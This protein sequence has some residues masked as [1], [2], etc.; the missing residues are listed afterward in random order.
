MHLTD[1]GWNPYFEQHYYD[2][3]GVPARVSE[4]NRGCYRV[5]CEQ[6]EFLAYVPGRIRFQAIDRSDFPAV[7]D[8]I[9][10]E[11]W[12]SG[13]RATIT[14]ILPRRT[15]LSRKAAG[16]VAEEQ[17]LAANLDT[18]FIVTSFNQDF[19]LRRIERY[20][21]TVSQSG[22][23]PVLILNKVDV[24]DDPDQF[25]KSTGSL[26]IP[27]LALSAHTG[28]GMQQIR[29]HLKPGHTAAMIGSSGVGKSTILN[30]LT[31]E[32][33]QRIQ[34]IRLSDD[35]GK[36]TTTSRQ[37]FVIRDGGIL[38]DTP[39]IREL[40]LWDCD[41]GLEQAFEELHEYATQCR[42]RDCHHDGEPGCAVA[43][44]VEDGALD[45][46]RLENYKKL[47]AESRFMQS[48]I[49]VRVRQEQKARAKR[50]CKAQK[51]HYQD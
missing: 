9:V 45:S 3:A 47:L 39:G 28:E 13:E 12:P 37:L 2:H 31:G 38:I 21:A 1:L 22:A 6:G 17:I 43:R 18:V 4:E 15:I 42:F 40:Q 8:W 5:L 27:V 36:H 44:A 30:W 23:R 26:S 24:C 51:Q 35:R 11:S 33:V 50:A 29:Q 25:L 49:D 46:D 32:D 41:S 10:I 19:N 20:L 34:P 7:G 14:A 16:R 48:K